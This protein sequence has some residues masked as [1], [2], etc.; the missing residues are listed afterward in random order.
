[1][2]V[3]IVQLCYNCNSVQVTA[4]ISYT[5]VCV[6][7]QSVTFTTHTYTHTHTHTYTSDRRRRRIYIYIAPY[8]TTPDYYKS[9]SYYRWE[10]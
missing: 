1:M 3:R 9:D 7:L 5:C 6:W 10:K 8:P 4:H 2:P